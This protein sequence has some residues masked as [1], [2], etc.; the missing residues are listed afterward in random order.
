MFNL[1]TAEYVTKNLIASGSIVLAAIVGRLLAEVI[2]NR[3]IKKVE[4]DDT[5]SVSALEQRAQTLGSLIKNATNILIF[6]TMVVMIVSEWGINIAPILTG[7]GII[8]LAV[9]F[10][11]QSLVRDI[12]TGFF[13]LFENQFNIGDTIEISG[14][15]GRVKEMNLRTTV[16][17]TDEGQTLIIPN[18]SIAVIK[19]L[20]KSSG[21]SKQK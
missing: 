9:G 1:E 11:A 2:I 15:T 8:G 5:S 14:L 3:I 17:K 12:V 19:K 4:D 6:G 7:A 18:S 21:S 16:L 20:P 10:G 13:I